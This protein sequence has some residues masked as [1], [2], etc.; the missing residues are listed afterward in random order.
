MK[1]IQKDERSK[2]QEKRIK[3][4]GMTVLTV[5]VLTAGTVGIVSA[6]QN[7]QDYK[8]SENERGIQDNQVVFSDDEDTI[9]H[10][11][12]KKKDN[13][14][15]LKKDQKGDFGAR[16][17]ENPEYLFENSSMLT[18]ENNTLSVASGGAGL[19]T[20]GGTR[21]GT[22]Y[23]LTGDAS[24]ADILINGGTSGRENGIGT[25]G[26]SKN[27][28]NGS[29]TGGTDNSNQ[30]NGNNNA[31]DKDNNGNQ[32]DR[33]NTRP[34][35]VV[36]DPDTEKKVPSK[37]S[38]TGGIINNPFIDSMVPNTETDENGEN[39]S[40]GIFPSMNSESDRLY[41]GQSVDAKT[42][43][44]VLDTY[45]AGK[46]GS[47][48][49]WGDNAYGTYI[50]ITGI[51]FDGGETWIDS[52]PVTIPADI[53]EGQMKIRAEYRVST[54]NE[55]WGTRIV[56]YDPENTRVFVLSREVAEGEEKI[57]PTTILNTGN[58][59]PELN[60]KINLLRIQSDYLGSER[61][62]QLF[63]GWM[64][65]GK[66]VPWFYDVTSGRHVLEPADM[67]PLDASYVVNINLFWMS[68]DY[69]VDNQYDNLCYLQTL[70]DMDTPWKANWKDEDWDAF[71]SYNVLDVPKYIQAVK[72]DE[73]AG[74]S[75]NYITIPDTVLYIETQNSGMR[76]NQGYIVD[77]D[78]LNYS[79]TEEGLLMN[80][81][82]TEILN[83]PYAKTAI[84]IP[85]TVENV[86]MEKQ[87]QLK[88]ITVKRTAGE[89]LPQI[90]YGNLKNCKIVVDDAFV[91]EILKNYPDE[92]S[93][94]TGN[95]VAPA[96]DETES[97]FV[98][99]GMIVDKEG[100]L[101]KVISTG[102]KTVKLSDHISRVL[103]NAFSENEKLTSVIMPQS[104][105][106][107]EFEKGS[108]ENST[109][110][111][112]LC[113]E[114]KQYEDILQQITEYGL[115][116]I[117]VEMIQVS[118][119]GYGYSTAYKDGVQQTV[120]INAP[121]DVEM[122]D[123]I[124]TA[125]DGSAVQITEIGDNAFNECG[126]LKWAFLPESVEKIGSQAFY[127]CGSLQGIMIR[128]KE[129]ISI[130]YGA[131]DHCDSLRFVGSNAMDGEFLDGYDPN[132]TDQF[133]ASMKYF[134]IPTGS[135]GYGSNCVYFT[136][137]SGIYGYDVIS[138]GGEG[139]I[140]YGLDEMNEPWITLR[141]GNTVPEK[142]EL[143][144][145]TTEIYAYTFAGTRT[146]SGEYYTVNFED[147]D[148][149]W[150]DDGAFQNSD[151][152]KNIVVN[153]DSVIC[154]NAFY[155]CNH[156]ESAEFPGT[157][158]LALGMNVL[159]ECKNL[160]TARIG[161]I[162]EREFL[163][164]GLFNGCEALT[165]VYFENEVPPSLAGMMST[166]KFQF[167]I[168][169]T[170]EEES[171]RL[172]IHV[173]EGT[174]KDYVKA[175]R[176]NFVGYGDTDYQPAYL[177][178][179]EEIR[180]ENIDWDTWE[181]PENSVVDEK[182]KEEL[183]L[184]ENRLR[185]MLGMDNVE[186]PVD[187]YPYHKDDWGMLR[188]AGVPSDVTKVDLYDTDLMGLPEGWYFDG[189]ESYAFAA[190]KNLKEI[191]LPYTLAELSNNVFAGIE[192]DSL[193]VTFDE[194]WAI[195]LVLED[196][197]PFS[198]GVD[199]SVLHLEVPE[200]VQDEYLETWSYKFAGYDDL[201]AMRAAV[202][203]ELGAA[204]EEPSD[205]EVDT[206]IAGRLLP[207]VNRLR[208]MMGLEEVETLDTEAFGLNI[209]EETGT[210]AE[211]P[212]NDSEETQ[213]SGTEQKNKNP[214]ADMAAEPAGEQAAEE[215]KE[216]D[217]DT[218]KT[219][220]PAGTDT[221]KPEEIE[222]KEEESISGQMLSGSGEETEK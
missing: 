203:A 83:I 61:L 25:D 94:E 193:T 48:Y 161:E 67:V 85:D 158:D 135:T 199:D 184:Y 87:N 68:D 63:P 195:D 31:G 88:K 30:N 154:D 108:L 142:L 176:Y 65:D 210:E 162:G 71:S 69:I 133:N 200:E 124:V 36:K 153:S 73:D 170:G 208:K 35:A 53:E 95:T 4:A 28:G 11:K 220:E 192:T 29:Q 183:L 18:T 211:T 196:G 113:Y 147:T 57:D 62:T 58:Q 39:L 114:K 14:E 79:S 52:F 143:P 182:L 194:Y 104:G 118:K 115:T 64:E 111:E 128:N 10:K 119:E 151:I 12:D 163:Y 47:L 93:K 19:T 116:N 15:L 72:I 101:R 185:T 139:W 45:V 77:K 169:W 155:G 187:F 214:Q 13:S 37:G 138:D 123:G 54:K 32:P 157:G 168:D 22:V 141:S 50:K 24:N 165:D 202:K 126:K 41:K 3:K 110:S 109:I 204:G 221:G 137:N 146:E 33:D 140:L 212:E 164:T 96:S 107:I 134:Y 156:I 44:N 34:S 201:E 127:G 219:E 179:W 60:A 6:Y 207:Q 23:N 180:V 5:S 136:E 131:I 90:S 144:E 103:E 91:E 186:E 16:N 132:V 190:A 174:E 205:V 40:V 125:E 9:G 84:T 100:N 150:I 38:S 46:D 26:N 59:Y 171:Q 117:T 206:E 8:P 145:T 1:N 55:K 197:Q 89:E 17:E 217:A 76:V 7:G 74:L 149:F 120:L 81:A 198:F 78:N 66:M 92:F 56:D 121:A 175:W 27:N 213:I 177:A 178:M 189:I 173:P 20:S 166:F 209:Q 75:V 106:T 160:K 181:F 188:L 122:F 167:N 191:V 218:E 80:K 112:I 148:I 216:T 49:W 152:G 105:K 97:F 86:Q 222:S 159:S 82:E 43:Y 21:N 98:E 129:K 172:K 130:G 51:S 2:R 42:I 99:N 70:T 102:N 215:S